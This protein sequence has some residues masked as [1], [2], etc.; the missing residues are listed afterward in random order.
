VQTAHGASAQCV[1]GDARRARRISWSTGGFE[2]LQ[3]S[4][5]NADQH[6]GLEG[7]FGVSATAAKAA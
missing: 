4:L 5:R 2:R 3:V 1:F 6:A 7:R